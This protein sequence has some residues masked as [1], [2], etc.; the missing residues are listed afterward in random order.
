MTRELPD[1]TLYFTKNHGQEQLVVVIRP[2][3]SKQSEALVQGSIPSSL[4][5][6]C[7]VDLVIQGGPETSAQFA[8]IGQAPELFRGEQF[9]GEIEYD[10]DYGYSDDKGPG[11]A[12]MRYSYSSDLAL[13]VPITARVSSLLF[14]LREIPPGVDVA[15]ELWGR[16]FPPEGEELEPVKDFETPPTE[17]ASEMAFAFRHNDGGDWHWPDGEGSPHFGVFTDPY[18]NETVFTATAGLSQDALFSLPNLLIETL[19][20]EWIKA[21]EWDETEYTTSPSVGY[22]QKRYDPDTGALLA[23]RRFFFGGSGS[24]TAGQTCSQHGVPSL[25]SRWTIQALEQTRIWPQPE[26]GETTSKV[27]DIVSAFYY[28]EP[29]LQGADTDNEDFVGIWALEDGEIPE[30]QKQGE[31]V[32]SELAGP[33]AVELPPGGDELNLL[34][35]LTVR[36]SAAS[37]EFVPAA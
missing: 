23:E 30:R 34:G 27:A 32:V 8:A 21:D 6:Y 15:V 7:V 37:I 13:L 36:R 14:D 16:V 22:L 9:A 10:T 17:L 20:N 2:D 25:Q 28:G 33:E 5:N 31:V 4:P 11:E 12:L 29:G 26:P 19:F 1:R 35:V 24:V 18:G 3:T